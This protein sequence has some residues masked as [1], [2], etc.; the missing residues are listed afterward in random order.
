MHAASSPEDKPHGSGADNILSVAMLFGLISLLILSI[1]GSSKV[2][3]AQLLLTIR[4][5][6]GVPVTPQE[7]TLAPIPSV[8]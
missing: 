6:T 1:A 4:T 8:Y 2:T 5:D 7:S 3:H